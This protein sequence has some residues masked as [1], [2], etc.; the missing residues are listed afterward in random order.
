MVAF[1]IMISLCVL[2]VYGAE[3]YDR[4]RGSR[5][6]LSYKESMSKELRDHFF[7][8]VAQE[9]RNRRRDL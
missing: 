3:V 7:N 8:P 5:T 4:K 2:V 1:I 9:M 6:N